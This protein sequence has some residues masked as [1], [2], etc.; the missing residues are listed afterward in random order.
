[1]ELIDNISRLLG[2][3]L[4]QALKLDVRLKIGEIAQVN[5]NIKDQ[6]A[7]ARSWLLSRTALSWGTCLG[8]EDA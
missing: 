1:M 7:L 6:C 5:C 8:D 2:D 4:K 3:N